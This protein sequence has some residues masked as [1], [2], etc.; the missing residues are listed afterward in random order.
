VHLQSRPLVGVA[1]T[2]PHRRP[3]WSNDA[4][5][6]PKSRRP[7][8][9]LKVL[10]VAYSMIPDLNP[11]SALRT[12]DWLH[13]I[14]RELDQKII[15]FGRLR[16][17]S[18]LSL[19][20]PSCRHSMLSPEHMRSGAYTCCSNRARCCGYF[21]DLQGKEHQVLLPKIVHRKWLSCGG[22]SHC[23]AILQTECVSFLQGQVW[24]GFIPAL[25]SNMTTSQ[26][27]I[28]VSAL[29]SRWDLHPESVRRIIR[30]GHLP[31]LSF[32]GRLRVNLE[33]VTAYEQ[34]HRVNT[35]T[36]KK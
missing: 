12:R 27:Y 26:K 25:F 19:L 35:T 13:P 1:P 4:G 17:P 31:A 16:D 24:N 9:P 28:D 20:K 34:S 5:L 8:S 10:F 23:E 22:F 15:R 29:Q 36:P 21:A 33:D 7:A 11:L 18:K 2:E 14:S 32:G 30:S 3:R 6:R